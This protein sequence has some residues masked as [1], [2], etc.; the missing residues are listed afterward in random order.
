MF[1]RLVIAWLFLEAASLILLLLDMLFGTPW[2][3]GSLLIWVTVV[4]FFGFIGFLVYLITYRQPSRSHHT[5]A[6]LT[7]SKSAL[8]S[9]VW[10]V[11]ANL[12]GGILVI[13]F[14]LTF[15]NVFNEAIYLQIMFSLLTP[16]I[17][18]I[19][20]Y[21][22]VIL[23]S[24]LGSRYRLNLRRPIFSEIVSTCLVLAGAYPVVI[25]L[26]DG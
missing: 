25:M 3:F 13:G 4:L 6:V 10:S 5:E 22:I 8:G 9:T 18:G 11:A 14:I 16:F 19:L 20:V 26:I 7:I 15:P 17:T 21:C 12:L 1:D 2:T 23:L 24:K